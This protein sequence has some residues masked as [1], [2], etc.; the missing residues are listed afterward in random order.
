MCTRT[1]AGARLEAQDT[2]SFFTNNAASTNWTVS[3]DRLVLAFESS[4]GCRSR[5]LNNP[6][7]LSS[8]LAYTAKLLMNKFE[9]PGFDSVEDR[10]ELDHPINPPQPE[11]MHQSSFDPSMG[12]WMKGLESVS[13]ATR[14]ALIATSIVFLL[15]DRPNQASFKRH[16]CMLSHLSSDCKFSGPWM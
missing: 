8:D 3:L 6:C 2:L 9:T 16:I 11:Q 4:P 1:R 12:H 15:H 5:S 7:S 10:A 13:A 14:L